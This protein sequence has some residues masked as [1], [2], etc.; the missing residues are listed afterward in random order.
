VAVLRE[1]I[2]NTESHNWIHLLPEGYFGQLQF[3]SA[4]S[5]IESESLQQARN[6]GRWL[7]ALL[8]NWQRMARNNSQPLG[9]TRHELDFVI[10][11]GCDPDKLLGYIEPYLD[12]RR[13]SM[14]D[15]GTASFYFF[16][17]KVI[18]IIC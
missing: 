3:T 1:K 16:F 9:T 10:Q 17:W 2:Y 18:D 8:E 12:A 13:D 14:R 15:Y 11:A 5:M 4:I 6:T 7:Q